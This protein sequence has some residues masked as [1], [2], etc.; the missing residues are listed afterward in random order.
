MPAILNP[1]T[2]VYPEVE[3]KRFIVYG[4]L[5]VFIN[6]IGKEGWIVTDFRRTKE[7]IA[8]RVEL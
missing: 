7:L 8:W 6:E 2:K 1:R 3:Y 4:D 5:L